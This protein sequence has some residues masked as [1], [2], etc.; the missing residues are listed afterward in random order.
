M[1]PKLV[2]GRAFQIIGTGPNHLILTATRAVPGDPE[3]H[4]NM[5]DFFLARERSADIFVGGRL[6]GA[7]SLAPGQWVGGKMESDHAKTLNP[8]DVLWVPAGHPQRVTPR[9][10]KP[11]RYMV[12]KIAKK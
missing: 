10:G 2:V 6:I 8:G 9:R 12:V 7:K 1:V 3:L 4:E 11:F 5:A